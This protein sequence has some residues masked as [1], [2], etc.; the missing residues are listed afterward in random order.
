VTSYDTSSSTI[1]GV[2]GQGTVT[3]TKTGVGAISSSNTSYAVSGATL[4][5]TGVTVLSGSSTT[6]TDEAL[7]TA[8]N[9]LTDALTALR[10]AASSLGNNNTLVQTRLDFTNSMIS[11]LSTASDNLTLADTN[12]E[13]ANLQALQ[14]QSQLGIVALGISGEQAQAILR[15]F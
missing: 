5:V 9:Q 14:A 12:E 4:T 15:L 3:A 13:G 2:T 11:T 1:S 6:V 10:S 8:Q 7:A